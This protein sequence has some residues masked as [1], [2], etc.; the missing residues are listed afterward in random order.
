MSSQVRHRNFLALAIPIITIVAISLG[1]LT[2]IGIEDFG[3]LLTD[4]NPMALA[5]VASA[6]GALLFL[7]HRLGGVIR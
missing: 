3:K 4:K 6:I 2:T 1:I 7:I 5:V